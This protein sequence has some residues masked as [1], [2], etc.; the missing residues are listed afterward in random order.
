MNIFDLKR[1][2]RHNEFGHVYVFQGIERAVMQIYWNHMATSCSCDVEFIDNVSAVYNT[3]RSLLEKP[4]LYVCNTDKDFMAQNE[5]VWNRLYTALGSNYMVFTV[6]ELDKRSRFYK[7]FENVCVEFAPLTREVLTYHIQKDI[8]LSSCAC[9]ELITACN[10][11]YSR[12]LLEIDKVKRIKDALPDWTSDEVLYEML[13]RDVI[14]HD[15]EDML[16][17]LCDAILSKDKRRVCACLDTGEEI[18]TLKLVTVLYNKAKKALLVHRGQ[19][20]KYTNDEI[21]KETGMKSA[22]IYAISKSTIIRTSEDLLECLKILRKIEKGIKEGII[23]E[24]QA[25]DYLLTHLL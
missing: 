15:T 8:D 21:S 13:D 22:E 9:N 6:D 2:I 20:L 17:P 3:R 7:H 4:K 23:C 1:Q 24:E 25:R 18:P 19:E 16:F 10:A 11:S 12:I 5:T 14:H